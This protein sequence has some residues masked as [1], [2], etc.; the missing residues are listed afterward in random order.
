MSPRSGKN[1]VA[2]PMKKETRHGGEKK[3]EGQGRKK[4]DLE[5]GRKGC[6][7]TRVAAHGYLL[8]KNPGSG[9]KGKS[10]S[11]RKKEGRAGKKT[12]RRRKTSTSRRRGDRC[13]SGEKKRDHPDQ[14]AAS[15]GE[16]RRKGRVRALRP[17]HLFRGDG[18]RGKMTLPG[19]LAARP[20]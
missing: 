13:H 14:A 17:G 4:N 18:E 15:G 1:L 16:V 12:S 8:I 20:T 5:R 6:Y 11:C 3:K 10:G 19:E 2:P 9:P 7:W